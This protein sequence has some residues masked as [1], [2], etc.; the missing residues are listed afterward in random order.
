MN[1]LSSMS[2]SV[3][4]TFGFVIASSVV[5]N[6]FLKT[7]SGDAPARLL[8]GLLSWRSFTGL[9]FFGI[10]GLAYSQAVRLVPLNVAQSL[11]AIQYI[12]IIVASA[13]LLGEVIT[14][15]RLAGIC[16]IAAGIVC[17][18]CSYVSRA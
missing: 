5:A 3:I 1:F 13:F 12:A 15:L 16:M 8:L 10:G 4:A 17:V 18:A 2:T 11:M 14:P 7:G 9:C 6:L